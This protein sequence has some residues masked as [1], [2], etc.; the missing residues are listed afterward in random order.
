M[1]IQQLKRQAEND[2][3]KQHEEVDRIVEE[4]QASVL[5]A[6]QKLRVSDSHFNPTT[7][8]GYDDFGRDTLEA[9]YAE[10][11]RAEDAL[12]RPQIISGTHAI[13]TSLFGVL[14]PGDALLYITGE[15]YDTLEEVIGKNDG[16]D[17][18]SL[19]DFGVSYSS[20]PLTN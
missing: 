20:V 8:Y 9:L 10:I 15:P 5:N 6:F 7:G 14:R 17:T 11:F 18:G 19:I 16:Q 1:T 3:A 2:I 12:V 4:N 13:T